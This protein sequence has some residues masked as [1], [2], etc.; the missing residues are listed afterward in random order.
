VV[1][2]GGGGDTNAGEGIATSSTWRVLIIE[3][4]LVISSFVAWEASACSHRSVSLF[5]SC[6]TS[7]VIEL[8]TLQL[9]RREDRG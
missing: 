7:I 1:V 2:T 4:N 5:W 9:W 8:M 6:L 3:N